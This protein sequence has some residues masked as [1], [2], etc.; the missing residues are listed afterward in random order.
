[1]TTL[2]LAVVFG[3]IP[4]FIWLIFYVHEDF[5]NHRHKTLTAIAFLAGAL[6]TFVVLVI[7][8]K[9]SNEIS[10]IGRD[11]HSLWSFMV[12]GG[13]EEIAKFM[14]FLLIVRPQRV[15]QKLHEPVDAMV[16]MVAVGLGFATVENVASASQ[17][18]TDYG[19]GPSVF[20]T[21]ILRFLGATLLHTLSSGLIGYYWARALLLSKKS[22]RHYIRYVHIDHPNPEMVT[23]TKRKFRWHLLIQGIAL[24]IILHAVFNYLIIINGPT[25][26]A[27]VFL[28]VFAF[29]V[30]SDFEKLK[31]IDQTPNL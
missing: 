25:G 30:L 8:I 7:Q 9:V 15:F 10:F 29:F 27:I 17:I 16:A 5:R 4:G 13:I 28:V 12:L 20:E 6:S 11:P 2:I 23:V 3:S 18:L 19:L 31:H 24:A 21:V 22:Y 1:M 14:A 26:V